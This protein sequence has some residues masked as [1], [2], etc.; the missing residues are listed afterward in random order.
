MLYGSV[1]D[2]VLVS[3]M[4]SISMLR[5]N[6]VMDIPSGSVRELVR[7]GWEESV[8]LVITILFVLLRNY[9]NITFITNDNVVNTLFR[10]IEAS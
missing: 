10:I 4:L 1:L 9:I 6:S 8:A 3:A 2:L 5:D 7:V